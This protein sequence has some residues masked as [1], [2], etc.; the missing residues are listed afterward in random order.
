MI[1][2]LRLADDETMAIEWLHAPRRLLA[3][4]A[5]RSS[6]NHSY[7]ELLRGAAASRSP[8]ACRRSSRP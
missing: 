4:C 2:R 6:P 3:T 8:P 1:T 7:Y 5:A